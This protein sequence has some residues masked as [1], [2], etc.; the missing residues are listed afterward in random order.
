MRFAFA[1]AFLA[2]SVIGCAAMV[3][4]DTVRSEPLAVGDAQRIVV[5]R[6]ASIALATGYRRTVR[7]GSLWERTGR[8]PQGDVY[9]PVNAVFNI[10]GRQVHEAWLVI[11]NGKLVGFHLPGESRYSPLTP[12]LTLDIGASP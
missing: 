2:S 12:P 1:A 7:A 9:R 4:L 8:L 3:P 6:E 5:R 10:E 11:S